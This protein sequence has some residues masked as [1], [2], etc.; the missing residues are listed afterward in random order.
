[1]SLALDE[2]H[3][4]DRKRFRSFVDA[5]VVPLAARMDREER[6]ASPLIEAFGQEGFLGADIP[7]A[8]GGRGM[9]ALSFGLL[10]EELGRGCASARTLLTVHH[11]V[12][13]AIYRWGD[14]G[15][16]QRW[17]PR[18]AG[19]EIAAAAFS[20]AGAGSDLAAVATEAIPTSGGYL[21]TGR[22]RW[23]SF[24]QVARV[25]LVLART[26][27]GTAAFVV[28]RGSPGLEVSP[29][30]GLI[31]TRAAMTA[32]V[33]LKGCFVPD[34]QLLGKPGFGLQWVVGAA[35]D[36]GRNSVAWGCVGIAQ[37]C[38][39]TAAD[40]ASRRHQFGEAIANHQLV[41]RMLS[42][43]VVGTEAARLMCHR[44][45]LLK[46]ARDARHIEQ[47]TMAKYFASRR[48]MQAALD[49]VQICGAEGCSEGHPAQRYLR[50]AKVMEII[51]GSNEMHQIHIAELALRG[52]A[53]GE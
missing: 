42:E 36:H 24:G 49:A 10:A 7:T 5:Q 15:Q 3:H 20:E 51:E 30:H 33:E 13:H 48:A 46:Q 1:M 44:A 35:L 19:G 8:Y 23:T 9:D 12:A 38:L 31:G 43:M 6:F 27:T 32:D 25:F 40:H 26:K 14:E 29:L 2:S 37:A 53:A 47:T 18:L 21:L 17:L 45:S 52:R 11:M 50:D 39:E 41:R 22:K 28:E 34:E 16:R 4:A